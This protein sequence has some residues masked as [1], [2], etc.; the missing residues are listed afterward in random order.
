[1]EHDP[2]FDRSGNWIRPF[3]DVQHQP[4]VTPT[5]LAGS[6]SIDIMLS[7]EA[8]TAP[9]GHGPALLTRT[10]EGDIDRAVVLGV[11][12]LSS[13]ASLVQGRSVIG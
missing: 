13:L 8:P 2:T 11:Y 1:M 12:G 5:H 6:K 3:M 4:V 10:V 7:G 9:L